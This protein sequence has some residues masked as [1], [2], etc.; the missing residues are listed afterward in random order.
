MRR[1]AATCASAYMPVQPGVIRP[2]G[3]TQVI[4]VMI[5]PAPPRARAPRW[6]RWKS[7][8]EPS[9]ALY[10]SIGDTTTRLASVNPRSRNGVNIGGGAGGAGGAAGGGGGGG[11]GAGGAAGRGA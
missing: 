1:Q 5:R 3:D 4:S 2:S 11:G 7:F 8:G 6:T 9:S 10:M